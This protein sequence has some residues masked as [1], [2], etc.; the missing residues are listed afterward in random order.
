MKTINIAGLVFV[1][2]MSMRPAFPQSTNAGVRLEEGIAKEEADGDLKAAM[3]VYQKI[4]ADSSAPRDV[5]AKAL[6]RGRMLREAGAAG[7]AGL[8]ADRA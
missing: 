5:R 7:Q 2:L 3:A 8:R 4:A 6:L 1:A